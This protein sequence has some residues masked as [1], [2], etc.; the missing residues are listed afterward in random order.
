MARPTGTKNIETPEIMYQLFLDYVASIRD[1]P[2]YMVEQKKGNTIIPKNFNGDISNISLVKL[3]LRRPLTIEGFENYCAKLEI[4]QD[5]S[6]YFAN[7]EGRYSGYQTICSR[8]KREIREDQ[9]EGGLTN[10]YN[11]SITQ[12]L[13]GL[14]DKQETSN[15][16]NMTISYE[17]MSED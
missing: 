12:R 13:N 1:N 5:L 10:Q 4:I 2:I 3:P 6:Q 9:L 11:S 8:I 14:V 15:N 7:T 16:I 17:A